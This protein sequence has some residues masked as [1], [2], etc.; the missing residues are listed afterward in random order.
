M[1]RKPPS[2]LHQP[3]IQSGFDRG[4]PGDRGVFVQIGGGEDLGA[5]PAFLALTADLMFQRHRGAAHAHHAQRKGQG[6]AEQRGDREIAG[7]M[8]GRRAP[9][10]LPDDLMPGIA[11]MG[12][13]FLIHAVEQVEI[14]GEIGGAGDVAIAKAQ[15]SGG[16]EGFGHGCC[17][18][19]TGAS[20]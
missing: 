10:L 19:V 17:F 3:L 16:G 8:H 6:L 2:P 4:G 20:V 9:A 12:P 18:L 13:E 14:G 15:L 11:D 1:G 5:G 7:Q